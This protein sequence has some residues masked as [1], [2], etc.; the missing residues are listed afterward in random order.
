MPDRKLFVDAAR[1]SSG[2]KPGEWSQTEAVGGIYASVCIDKIPN[3]VITRPFRHAGMMMIATSFGGLGGTEAYRILA[4]EEFEQNPKNGK[5]TTYGEKVTRL[6]PDEW[7]KRP[8]NADRRKYPGDGA[9]HDP[10]GF[11]HGMQVKWA[12]QMYVITGPRYQ[13]EP[14]EAAPQGDLFG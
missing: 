11:Y 8:E 13:L 9:R 6:M 2:Y 10:F 12:G 5:P 14:I 1:L 3:G 7:Y 4:L